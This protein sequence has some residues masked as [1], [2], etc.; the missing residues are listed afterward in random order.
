ML[1]ISEPEQQQANHFID[2]LLSA[3]HSDKRL[4][5]IIDCA[6]HET[7]YTRL[8]QHADVY[9]SQYSNDVPDSLKAAGPVLYQLRKDN[10]LSAWIIT[11]GYQNNWFILFPSLGQTMIDLRRHFKRFAMVESPE[12]KA[13]YFRYYDPRVMRNYIPS[14]NEEERRYIFAKLS[15]FWAQSPTA[16]SYVQLN[17]DGSEKSITLTEPT[18]VAAV[19]EPSTPE[20]A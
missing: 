4:Y 3:S 16:N 17:N 19:K 14:C 15:C 5:A 1:S 2:Q 10:A 8:K 9:L 6:Q 18:A 12:G 20:P 13:M 11:Q 7:I